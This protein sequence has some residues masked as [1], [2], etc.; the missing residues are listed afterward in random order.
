MLVQ[1]VVTVRVEIRGAVVKMAKLWVNC[2]DVVMK[3]II[4]EEITKGNGV[5]IRDVEVKDVTDL[6]GDK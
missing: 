6:R 5:D 3:S 2:K 1:T 4:P